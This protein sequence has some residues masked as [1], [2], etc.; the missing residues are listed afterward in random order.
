MDPM[1]Y[2]NPLACIEKRHA[3]SIPE[4]APRHSAKPRSLKS[5][6]SFGE[7]SPGSCLSSRMMDTFLDSILFPSFELTKSVKTHKK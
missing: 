3:S 7:L 4:T 2:S 5:P 1:G 6:L